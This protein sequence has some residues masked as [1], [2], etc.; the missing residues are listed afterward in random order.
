MV[1]GRKQENEARC[2]DHLQ[3]LYRSHDVN[4][5]S[6]DLAQDV[7]QNR[8]EKSHIRKRRSRTTIPPSTVF[9]CFAQS[10]PAANSRRVR[11]QKRVRALFTIREMCGTRGFRLRCANRKKRRLRLKVVAQAATMNASFMQ[12]V[13]HR[14]CISASVVLAS[15]LDAAHRKPHGSV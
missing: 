10:L 2:E 11:Q 4:A 13:R 1:V 9:L 6:R 8:P 7:N 12:N 3:Q 14:G 15:R 5:V